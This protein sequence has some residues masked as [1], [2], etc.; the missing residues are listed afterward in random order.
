METGAY[1]QDLFIK[2]TNTLNVQLEHLMKQKEALLHN[3]YDKELNQ[4]KK[5]IPIIE[6]VL[7]GY[8]KDMTAE[9]KNKLLSTIIKEVIYTKEKGGRY[10]KDNFQLKIILLPFD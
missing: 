8:S 5:A 10:L 2:R 9:E 4:K 1:T 3:D 7:K 6:N